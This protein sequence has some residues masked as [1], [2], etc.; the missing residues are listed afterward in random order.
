LNGKPKAGTILTVYALNSDD[1]KSE[2]V[3]VTVLDKTPPKAPTITSKVTTS[4]TSLTGKGENASTVY[5]Y[6]GSKLL[7][8]AVV[9]KNGTYKAKIK[10]QKKSAKLT[11]YA[12]DKA[13]NKS[14]TVN[15]VVK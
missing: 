15:V 12:Q 11:V 4:S 14:K 9:A 1:N 8:K 13:G 7:G 10:A 3:K 5:I 6:N 2:P